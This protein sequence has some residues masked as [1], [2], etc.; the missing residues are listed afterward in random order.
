[1]KKNL[2][3]SVLV[4]AVLTMS[5]A[6]A[7]AQTWEFVNNTAVW[8]AEGVVLNGGSQYDENAAA[9]TTGGV[10]FTG[11]KGFVS[12]AK[13][14][15]FNTTGST[16]NENISIVVPV[17]YKA[18]VSVYTSNNRTVVAKLGE[19]TQ[20]FNANWASATKEFSNVEGSEDATLY[21]YCNQN[22]GGAD[23]KKAPFLERIVLTDMSKISSYPWT[24]KAV[25]NVGGTKTTIKTYNSTNDVDE[26]SE[27]TVIVEKV[28]KFEDKYY[29]LND[30][31]FAADVYGKAFTMGNAAAEIE[32]NYVELSDVVF[33][34]EV[35]DIYVEGKNANKQENISVLSNGGGYS[36]MSSNG[37]Y[38]K[39]G[40]SVPEDAAYKLELGMNNTNS[41]ERG[42]N[43]AIDDNE[44]SETITVGNGK[45]YVQTIE[46]QSLVE[47]EHTMTLNITYSLT[48]IFDYLIVTKTGEYV[49][50]GIEAV[51][52]AAE[53]AAI[54][55]LQGVRVEKAVK[56]LYIV[57]GR[58]VIV[59]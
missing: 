51:N 4:A 32:V 45:A 53:D 28:I 43:Y 34:G 10:T 21:L 38:V 42:F 8:A 3:K 6:N 57:G 39:I 22:A 19:T 16:E 33:Y 29:M 37:G 58:K 50:T 11:E 2:L 1:M 15:G 17:G 7:S 46:E 54:Y 20:T 40:F 14:L 9:V 36:A 48:P 26:G 59:K 18:S 44:V 47:G 27:Y 23:Q 55:N 5:G 41:R 52:A 35:E 13:G 12:T 31:Q 30:E 24:V 49:G 25:A 56:G